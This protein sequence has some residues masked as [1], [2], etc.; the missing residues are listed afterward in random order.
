MTG[1]GE[2]LKIK[3]TSICSI[4]QDDIS[5][6]AEITTCKHQFCYLC[7]LQWTKTQRNPN[8]PNCRTTYDESD[9]QLDD[10]RFSQNACSDRNNEIRQFQSNE[11]DEESEHRHDRVYMV[12]V[13][14]LR[15][16]TGFRCQD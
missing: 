4:C 7:L 16:R 15:R 2:V 11:I 13:F 8:C 6:V 10:D 1:R 5:E 12:Q 3:S 14:G 9:I